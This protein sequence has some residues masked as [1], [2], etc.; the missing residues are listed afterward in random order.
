MRAVRR[1]LKRTQAE[2]AGLIGVTQG[3]VSQWERGTLKIKPMSE[4]TLRALAHAP[5][6]RVKSKSWVK[7]LAAGAASA[8]FLYLIMGVK[9]K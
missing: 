3:A 2:M 7:W 9:K 5:D 1:K 6:D 4:R 8:A